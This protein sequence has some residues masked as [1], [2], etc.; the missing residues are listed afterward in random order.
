MNPNQN[1]LQFLGHSSLKIQTSQD[2]IVYIDPWL[3][4]NPVCP[5]EERQIAR[6]DLILITHGHDDHM[7]EDLPEI[8][9]RTGARVVAPAPVRFY[10]QSQGVTT[11]E[12]INVGGTIQILGL[13]V[14]MTQAKHHSWVD[15]AGGQSYFHEAAGYVLTLEDG[16]TIY[17]AGDTAVFGDME[18]IGKL[19][20]PDL[21]VLPIGDRFTMGPLEA[22]MAIRLLGVKKV[23][24][25]HYKTFKL[26]TGTPAELREYTADISDLEIIELRAG[27]WLELA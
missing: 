20:R 9:Q 10:L 18:L 11:L 19:Y 8:V 2:K 21:A 12:P 16:Y 17:F 26:L 6:A 7:D 4:K 14:T 27:D 1:R 25:V 3:K 22:A 13:G 24:P 5:P 15:T 23:L